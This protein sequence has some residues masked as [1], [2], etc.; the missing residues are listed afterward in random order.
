MRRKMRIKRTD[1]SFT[2][3]GFTIN[4]KYQYGQ[5]TRNDNDGPRTY[6]VKDKKV[7]SV[8]T[9]LSG[10]QS[11]QKAEALDKWRERIGYEEAARITNQ[12]ATR[13]TEMHYVL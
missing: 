6:N 1:S 13:G 2:I 10:T 8:T 7:P 9:I 5:Y 3:D 11:K 12:A 4:N